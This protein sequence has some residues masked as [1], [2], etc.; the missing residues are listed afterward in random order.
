MELA[1]KQIKRV[2]LELGGKSAAVLL[3]GAD[4]AK[5]V[6][7]TVSGCMLNSGQTCSA[8]TRLV[9][10]DNDYEEVVQMAAKQASAFVLGDPLADTTRLG[11]LV[12]K[13]Q[14]DR[15]RGF[16]D[17]GVA[18]GARLLAGD[19]KL[20]P[21]G[22]FVAPTILA[23]VQPQSA[24]AQQEIFG[25]VLSVLRY[26]DLDDAASIANASPYGLAG[27]VWGPDDDGALAFS[28]RIRTGQID[29]N[30]AHFNMLAP[31]G[32]FKQSG[33]G[34]ELGGFSLDEFVEIKSVQMPVHAT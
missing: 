4:L 10:S 5:A 18:D 3:P 34:R 19:A 14:Y 20:P 12:S 24:V 22:Y 13:T 16:I 7:N 31:F 28:R 26:R 21:T 15:V 9:V 1:A 23:D 11:P 17:R 25:P 8:L 29:I 33:F 6:K 27:A 2:R 30:G 32:G